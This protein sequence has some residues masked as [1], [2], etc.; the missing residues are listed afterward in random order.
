MSLYVLDT[1]TL[2]LLQYGHPTV[3]Q[4][5]SAVSASG[6]AT[7][8]ISVEEQLTGWQAALRRARQPD[9]IARVYGRFTAT[10]RFLSGLPILSFTEDAVRRYN[11]LAA[12]KL[13]VGKMDLRIAAIA[14]EFGAVVV[15]RNVR[16]FQRVPHLAVVDWTV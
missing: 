9:D 14:L 1:D 3:Q 16:D 11:A 7:T 2:S 8:I 10:V 12:L 5:V 4:H 13:N 6:L 15:T